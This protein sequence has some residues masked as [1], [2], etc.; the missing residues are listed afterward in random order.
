M[1]PEGEVIVGV[2][3]QWSSGKSTAAKTLVGHLGGEAEVVFIND[4]ILFAS[5]VID[6]IRELDSQINVSME[7]DGRR[8]LEGEC[9]RVRLAPG[10]DLTTVDL[11]TLLFEVDD[12]VLPAW[13]N[14]ARVELGHQIC[15]RSA[16]GKPIVIEAGFGESPTDHTISDLFVALGEVG[17]TPDRVK[18]IIVEA[19]YEKRS[20][21]NDRRGFGPPAAI[22]ARYAA[23]GGDLNPD[24]QRELEEQGAMI[25]RVSND[26]DD[27]QR[28]RADIIAAFEEMF[29][30]G[31]GDS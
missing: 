12:E 8:R 25:R 20:Q 13:L 15:E 29:G 16:E 31:S 5:Q 18:W 28:F 27:I 21:R 7:N 11:G 2:L 22:F 26:H 19:G 4:A 6:H 30:G 23:D 1:A 9:A 14:R 24:D 17:V 10:E 3:G